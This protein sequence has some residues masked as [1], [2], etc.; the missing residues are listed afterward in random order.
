[1]TLTRRALAA[2]L[3]AGSPA[4]A[5]AQAAPR[6]MT[7]RQAYAA[8]QAGE[9]VLVDIRTPAEWAETGS[10][11]G[12]ARIDVAAADFVRKLDAL[13]QANP[14]KDI[15]LICRSSNRSARAAE[16]LTREGWTNI[17]DVAGGV[18]GSTR[19]AGWIAEGL[20]VE[21]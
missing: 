6:A 1:M 5:F 15:A 11:K 10:P 18:A 12:A 7:P 19:G 20:P 13:R 16:R 8:Q 4:A 9:I 17:V 14:G 2:L 21:K 3:F